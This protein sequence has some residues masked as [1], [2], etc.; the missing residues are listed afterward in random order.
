MAGLGRPW[1]SRDDAA[2]WLQ[3]VAMG[4]VG[5]LVVVTAATLAWAL[6]LQPALAWWHGAAFHVATDA[7]TWRQR[8]R[9]A[10]LA[11]AT[12][13][14]LFVALLAWYCDGML[15]GAGKAEH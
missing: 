15:R 14:V 6:V 13:G 9:I 12:L 2:F 1:A 11:T 10:A 8:L 3:L 5:A 7:G 4:V